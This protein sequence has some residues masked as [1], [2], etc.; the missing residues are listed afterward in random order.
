MTVS[1]PDM[2]IKNKALNEILQLSVGFVSRCIERGQQKSNNI[3]II[4]LDKVVKNAMLPLREV[5]VS[6]YIE[7]RECILQ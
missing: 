6:R 3:A 4:V 7:R 5:F 1:V 2:F